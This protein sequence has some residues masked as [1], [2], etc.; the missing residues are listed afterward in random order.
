MIF[1]TDFD[2]TLL[3]RS[4]TPVP[5]SATAL[6]AARRR[7]LAVVPVTARGPRSAVA[8]SRDLD[9]GPV[10]VCSNGVLGVEVSTGSVL[11]SHGLKPR[12]V[13]EI[14]AAIARAVGDA[15]FA[16]ETRDGFLVEPGFFEPQWRRFTRAQLVPRRTL[17]TSEA[18]KVVTRVPGCSGE[19]LRAR[20]GGVLDGLSLIPGSSDWLDVCARGV[21]KG[22]GIGL[23]AEVLG[24]D[25]EDVGAVGD[26]LNDVSMFE[27]VGRAYVVADGHPAALRAADEVVAACEDGG[28][29]E[30]LTRFI[31]TH[32]REYSQRSPRRH[33]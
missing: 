25:L 30:A 28:A 22:S 10:C 7:G 8:L 27:V 21:S 31:Q 17:A 16:V 2:G 32:D 14:V 13:G 23:G 11:W 19:E 1:A 24:V 29:G 15:R 33:R 12:V 6:A 3:D 18:L 20:L 9:L 5:T 26:H 4:G